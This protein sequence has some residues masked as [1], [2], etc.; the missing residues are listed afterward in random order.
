MSNKSIAM[1]SID[2]D[3]LTWFQSRYP[4]KLSSMINSYLRGLWQHDTGASADSNNID[5]INAKAAE[6]E[7]K[8]ADASRALSEINQAYMVTLN[9]KKMMEEQ[10]RVESELAAAQRQA[11]DERAR[12]QFKRRNRMPDIQ[13]DRQ[14][15]KAIL[16]GDTK[17]ALALEEAYPLLRAL[18][19]KEAERAA[20]EAQEASP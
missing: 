1:V 19:E 7:A 10:M 18:R 6:L 8:K 20:K 5:T 17:Q 9:S 13:I 2:S 14:Y 16:E 12:E 4:R 11:D 3:L 15:R